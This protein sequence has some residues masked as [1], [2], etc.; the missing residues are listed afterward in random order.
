MTAAWF[1]SVALLLAVS[2]TA[3][4]VWAR[5]PDD[6]LVRAAENGDLQKV[7]ALLQKGANPNGADKNDNTPLEGAA[8]NGYLP[9]VQL[10][11]AKGAVVDAGSHPALLAAAES[12]HV[13]VVEALLIKGADVKRSTAPKMGFAFSVTAFAGAQRKDMAGPRQIGSCQGL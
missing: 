5:G 3:Y 12:G 2:G 1:T 9:I 11:L 13:Q 6:N 4:T 10:L 8:R 7:R